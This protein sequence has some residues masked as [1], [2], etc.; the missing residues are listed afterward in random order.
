MITFR[1][2]FF[3]PASA[4]AVILAAACGGQTAGS[5]GGT[6][7]GSGGGSTACDDYFT[8]YFGQGCA[9][10]LF[11]PSDVSRAQSRWD[12][13]C[14]AALSAPGESV[15]ASMLESCAAAIQSGGCAA[16]AEKA[17]AFPLAG[18]LAAGSPC[19]ADSQ[20]ASGSCSASAPQGPAC[21]RCNPTAPQGQACS[22][23]TG[24]GAGAACGT[25][26]CQTITYGASGAA[27]QPPVSLCGDG[28]VC[29]SVTQTCTQPVA[30]G[31]A[32][33]MPTDC[34]S[35]LTCVPSAD[36]GVGKDTCQAPGPAGAPCFSSLDCASGLTC[37][38]TKQ[39]C[40]QVTWAAAGESC[41]GAVQCA[42][43]NCSI[44]FG[45]TGTGTC[46]TVI[47]DGQP[48]DPASASTTCDLLASCVGG[49]CTLDTTTACN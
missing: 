22:G 2:F 44:A 7:T 32:C 39:Q 37:D 35:T 24:C 10:L 26:G 21:G 38:T 29:D 47:A 31:G 1:S 25:N 20:C 36:P 9:G 48:C 19:V 45:T 6:G 13:L 17:C 4:A 23:N 34:A 14:Q 15:T 41:G 28:L 43:G 33:M 42:I 40:A 46:P 16:N 11:Q 8:A 30:A 5:G 27:C 3:F 12:T 49:K 18:T